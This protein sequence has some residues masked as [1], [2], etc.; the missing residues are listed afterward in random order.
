[1]R[2]EGSQ[3]VK[4]SPCTSGL[5]KQSVRTTLPTPLPLLSTVESTHMCRALPTNLPLHEARRSPIAS[6]P[7]V[8][9][10]TLKAQCRERIF[11][12]SSA[13]WMAVLGQFRNDCR[14]LYVLRV[15][16]NCGG[17]LSKRGS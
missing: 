4:L 13:V 3:I 15:I 14:H 17:F 10:S 11:L 8:L 5:G 1:E 2:Q 12:D 6:V 7:L 16:T 9:S